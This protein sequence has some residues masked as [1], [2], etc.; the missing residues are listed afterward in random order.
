[1]VE[2][3]KALHEMKVYDAGALSSSLTPDLAETRA[4]DCTEKEQVRKAKL[5]AKMDELKRASR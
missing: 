3:G 4:H 5:K 2:G 1:M